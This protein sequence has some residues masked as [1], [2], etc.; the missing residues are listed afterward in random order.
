[1]PLSFVSSV[2]LSVCLLSLV[3]CLF[4]P[5]APQSCIPGPPMPGPKRVPGGEV[6]A[7]NCGSV[8]VAADFVSLVVVE[9][10]SSAGL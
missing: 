9:R 1:M 7:W 3:C 6:W 2:S 10:L 4:S 5:F 8:G